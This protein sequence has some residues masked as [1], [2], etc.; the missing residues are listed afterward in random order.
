MPC[1]VKFWLEFYGILVQRVAALLPLLGCTSTPAW[2]R[3][4]SAT[5]PEGHLLLAGL[6]P[7]RGW[8]QSRPAVLL[9]SPQ[10]S[11]L[12]PAL[13]LSWRL[14]VARQSLVPNSP[15]YGI[16]QVTMQTI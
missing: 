3:G 13:T 7:H 6:L 10:T 15:G 9:A 4:V 12:Y 8:T 11:L 1:S 5:S 14:G 16:R 2:T